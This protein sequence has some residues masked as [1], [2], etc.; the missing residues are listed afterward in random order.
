MNTLPK[1]LAVAI[2]TVFIF[3]SGLTVDF[4]SAQNTAAGSAAFRRPADLL[5]SK[6]LRFGRLTA[7]DGLSN[8]FYLRLVG[9]S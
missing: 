3:I 5:L 7:E 1:S 2:L 8:N 6:Y 4:A 9:H